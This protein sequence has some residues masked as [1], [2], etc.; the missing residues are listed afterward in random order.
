[1]PFKP[2]ISEPQLS[3]KAT[4][5]LSSKLTAEGSHDRRGT[6]YSNMG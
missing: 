5:K 1:M 2:M 6:R 4:F 3:V